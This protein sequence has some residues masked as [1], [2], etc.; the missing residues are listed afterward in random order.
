MFLNSLLCFSSVHTSF[1]PS[2]FTDA[3][4]WVGVFLSGGFGCSGFVVCFC[5]IFFY[6]LVWSFLFVL[7]VCLGFLWVF[8]LFF[9]EQP[10]YKIKSVYNANRYFFADES[11]KLRD[12]T[13]SRFSSMEVREISDITFKRFV[14]FTSP[15]ST[16]P[17]CH[18]KAKHI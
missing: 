8:C 11:L 4:Y 14:H 5:G 10:Q 17:L 3:S 1:P 13:T 6:C 15:P 9:N 2:W 16:V 18:L 12:V 7:F